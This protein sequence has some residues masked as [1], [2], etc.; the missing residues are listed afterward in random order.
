MSWFETRYAKGNRIDFPFPA[1]SHDGTTYV[2]APM[3]ELDAL[4]DAIGE[5]PLVPPLVPVIVMDCPMPA[6]PPRHSW[7]CVDPDGLWLYRG[8]ER[9]STCPML[10]LREWNPLNELMASLAPSSPDAKSPIIPRT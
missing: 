8:T 6:D 4:R 10:T 3:S 7:I 9:V 1:F 2:H 5:D